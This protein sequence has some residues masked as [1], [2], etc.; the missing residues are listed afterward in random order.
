MGKAEN[1]EMLSKQGKGY[2]IL[3]LPT[4]LAYK[5]EKKMK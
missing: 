5:T 2:I 3:T 1:V 4:A